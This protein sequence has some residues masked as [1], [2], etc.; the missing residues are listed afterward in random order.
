MTIRSILG[1]SSK[2]KHKTSMM[3]ILSNP[4]IFTSFV[5]TVVN[6]LLVFNSP[7]LIW[8][9]VNLLTVVLEK[10]EYKCDTSLIDCLTQANFLSILGKEN[11]LLNDALKDMSLALLQTFDSEIQIFKIAVE[12]LEYRMTHRPMQKVTP[13]S[14]YFWAKIIA[15]HSFSPDSKIIMQKLFLVQYI[16][17][18]LYIYI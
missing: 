9:L 18:Y 4:Q 12:I 7:S 2:Q 13:E 8:Q 17:I 15:N 14:L 11:E 10:R 1:P 3:T 16:Y 6:L 5:G